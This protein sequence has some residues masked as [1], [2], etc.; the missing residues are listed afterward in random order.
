M[1]H[2][3]PEAMSKAELIERSRAERARFAEPLG[4]LGRDQMLQPNLQGKWSVKDIIAHVVDWEERMVRWLGETLRGETPV[5]PAPGLTWAD[6]DQLNE[7][8]Y[9]THKDDPLDEVL[10]RFE[11]FEPTAISAIEAVPEQDLLASSRYPWMGDG[12]LWHLVAANT[13]WH[14]PAHAKVIQAA[15]SHPCECSDGETHQT[16]SRW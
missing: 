12:P 8:T 3:H 2:E 7:R 1:T 13:F 10:S 5:M 15:F 4:D 14:Y 16:D 6:I 9:L 11:E